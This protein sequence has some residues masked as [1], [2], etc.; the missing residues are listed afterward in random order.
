MKLLINKKGFIGISLLSI[1]GSIFF[2]IILLIMIINSP[3]DKIT[4]IDNYDKSYY[5]NNYGD[6]LD[7]DLSI[8]PD[9]YTDFLDASF[10]SALSTLAFDTSGY[11][12]LNA[13]YSE[14]IFKNEIERIK[15]LKKTVSDGCRGNALKYTNTV[16][17]DEN[18][19]NLP[20][21]IA[22]DGFAYTYEYALIDEPNLKITYVYLSYPNTEDENY[23]E[24]LKK[25]KS[26]YS[27]DNTLHLFS[28]YKHSF[29]NGKS[30]SEFDD[31]E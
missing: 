7:S 9:N 24:Y 8:F 30:Y 14:E 23:Y 3:I 12:I 16:L 20:A 19:Y 21:Y 26:G 11:I 17:Y 1:V 13:K 27:K 6:D 4:G 15:Q 2:V 5:I 28:M 29:D 22:I 10:S 18:S 25:D 31:C